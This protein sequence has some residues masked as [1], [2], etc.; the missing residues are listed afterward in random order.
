MSKSHAMA[1]ARGTP[2]VPPDTRS[3]SDKPMVVA[4]PSQAGVAYEIWRNQSFGLPVGPHGK[5]R[6]YFAVTRNGGD[7]ERAGHHRPGHS[8]RLLRQ[9][10]AFRA[11]TR[12][13]L[14]A[15]S[16]LA[17]PSGGT[18]LLAW[19]SLDGGQVWHGP[20]VVRHAPDGALGPICGQSTAGADTSS[21]AGRQTL[22]EGRSVVLVT[23]DG[24]SA[25]AGTG[26][27]LISRSDDGGKTW[28]TRTAIRSAE[29]HPALE[30]VGGYARQSGA[31]LG[32]EKIPEPSTAPSP[33]IPTRSL[34][35]KSGDGGET[36]SA[37][38]T[39]GAAWWNL[40][41][42]SAEVGDFSG[43]FVGDYQALASTPSGFATVTVQGEPLRRW[44]TDDHGRERRDGGK[45][46]GTPGAALAPAR[47]F[48][49]LR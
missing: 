49:R 36:W 41:S 29:P 40:A 45:R 47:F 19:R 6:L 25:A 4:D 26:E 38:V 2:P 33:T 28:R 5:T 48:L 23:I 31:P 37:P 24:P 9:P 30:R 35:A 46:S 18:D 27:I 34:F 3:V 39:L 44:S 43:Y 14:V 13:E 7:L 11:R 21:A 8:L 32:R 16:S 42:G 10:P 20:V 17:D 1:A 12:G 15:T 22:I